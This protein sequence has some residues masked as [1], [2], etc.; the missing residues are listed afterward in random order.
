VFTVPVHTFQKNS[1]GLYDALG[2]LGQMTNSCADLYS[3]MF[4]TLKYV[5]NKPNICIWFIE[6]GGS[7]LSSRLTMF[8]SSLGASRVDVASNIDGFRLLRDS[9]E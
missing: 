2:N 3:D 6:K 8:S 7:W 1:F 9:L 4:I 5:F